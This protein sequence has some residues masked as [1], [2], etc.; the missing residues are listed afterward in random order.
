MAAHWY[1]LQAAALY[2]GFFVI[3][4]WRFVF[5]WQTGKTWKKWFNHFTL[6]YAL[7]GA[8]YLW[9]LV[10]FII[11]AH[12]DWSTSRH[13]NTQRH[14]NSTNSTM[15]YKYEYMDFVDG[16]REWPIQWLRCLVVS[17]P[18]VVLL[19]IVMTALQSRQHLIEI[20]QDSAQMQH[21]RVINILAMPAVYCVVAMSGLVRV[22]A[23]VVEEL[24]VHEGHNVWTE[25]EVA[26]ATSFAEYA[27][28]VYVGD[29]YEAW[30]L[31]QFSALT[32]ELLQNALPER[33][34][35]LEDNGPSPFIGPSGISPRLSMDAISSVMWLGTGLF[36]IVNMVQ[37]G[38]SLY[39][40]F[41]QN[42]ADHWAEF[43]FT[44]SRFSYAGMVASAAAIYN[45]HIIERTFG[46]FIKGYSPFLKFLSVK[47]LVFFA[48]W[49]GPCLV[50]LQSLSILPFTDVQ[51]KLLQATLLVF[52]CLLCACLHV[53]AWNAQEQWYAGVDEKTPL[54]DQKLSI[55]P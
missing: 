48:F 33:Q 37:T 46:Y 4:V 38:W 28:C 18:A 22:Y 9:Q 14:H 10:M 36:I 44:L 15:K 50:M 13:F 6:L 42:P 3:L 45:V 31:F 19:I 11:T 7:L 35:A 53:F 47:I 30:A 54:M 12:K 32:I 26:K 27:T 49:Q 52:E 25:W 23:L 55:A 8:L 5:P 29:L 43:E 2:V 40:W 17:V 39:M 1:I 24:I 16:E 41:F 20:R 51:L 34:E 21:D